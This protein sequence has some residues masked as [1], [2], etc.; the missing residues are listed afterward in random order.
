MKRLINSILANPT[1]AA[2]GA[3]LLFLLS[4]LDEL[5]IMV[6]VVPFIMKF[7]RDYKQNRGNKDG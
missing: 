1:K 5:I 3:T 2:G 6:F 4:P 7:I